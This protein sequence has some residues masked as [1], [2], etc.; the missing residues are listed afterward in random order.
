[1]SSALMIGVSGLRGV[2]GTSLTPEVAARF[3]GVFGGWLVNTAEGKPVRVILGRDG[4]VGNAVIYHAA[5]AGL[6]FLRAIPVASSR[7]TPSS[8]TPRRR[9]R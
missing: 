3:A 1:M 7:N 4:R 2:I 8:C 5:T 9:A 6:L